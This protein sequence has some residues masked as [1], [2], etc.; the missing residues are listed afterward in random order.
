M[1]GVFLAA[2]PGVRHQ[3]PVAGVRAVDVAPTPAYLLGIP[4][5]Q[6][7]RGRILYEILPRPGQLKEVTTLDISDYHGQ[8]VPLSEA[9]DTVTGAGAANPSFSIG[10][11]RS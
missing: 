1:H 6:N 2:G 5:P 11:R 10:D 7:A 4:G 8:L 9:A 3:D